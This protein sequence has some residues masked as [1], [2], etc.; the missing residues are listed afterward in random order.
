MQQVKPKWD[1]CKQIC[2]SES[3]AVMWIFLTKRISGPDSLVN[4]TKLQG[5]TTTNSSQ[6]LP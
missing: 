5:R 4:F 3:E 6:T 2:N 1:E